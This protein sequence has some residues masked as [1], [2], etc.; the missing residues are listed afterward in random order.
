MKDA[1]SDRPRVGVIGLGAFGRL[2]A[3]AL[4]ADCEVLGFD[5]DPPAQLP[6]ARITD[7]NA[8]CDADA[9]VLAVNLQHLPSACDA[10]APKLKSQSLVADVTSVK[11]RPVDRMRASLP[12][13]VEILGTHPLFGPQSVAERGLRGLSVALCPVRMSDAT[14]ARVRALLEG[15]LGLRLIETTPDEHDRQMAHVQALTHLVGHA[16][17]SLGVEE[18]PLAT[19][20]YDRLRQ[21]ALNISGD[22]DELFETIQAANPYAA[23]VRRRFVEAI[24]QVR[25]RAGDPPGSAR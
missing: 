2:A 23:D 17:A 15:R 9:V 20:A 5:P 7:L 13:H 10:I 16:A 18:L 11:L 3:T 8:V 19:I 12:E 6:G 4:A 22:S 14:M 21:L 1:A 24:E 25:R